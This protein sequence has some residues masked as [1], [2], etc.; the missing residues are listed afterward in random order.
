MKKIFLAL[1]IVGCALTASAQEIP[2]TGDLFNGLTRPLTFNRMIPPYAL[3]VVG[4]LK[5]SNRILL[6]VVKR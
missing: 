4:Q 5:Q 2:S 1:A 6:K 3:E